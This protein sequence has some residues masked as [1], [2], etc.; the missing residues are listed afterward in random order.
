MAKDIQKISV[1]IKIL[2]Y[3]EQQNKREFYPKTKDI[4]NYLYT[5][6]F[7]I[8]ERSLNRYISSIST[9]FDVAIEKTSHQGGYYINK[10]G[11]IYFDDI[12][13]TLQLVDKA[14]YFKGLLQNSSD[15]LQYFSFYATNFKGFEWI[16]VIVKAIEHKSIIKFKHK[17]FITHEESIREIEPYLLKEYLDR[18]YV[19][20]YDRTV[21]ENRSFGL[22]RISDLEIVN[23]KFKK[24]KSKEIKQQFENTIGLVY[25]EPVIVRLSFNNRLIDYFKAN[26]W[27]KDYKIIEET[28]DELI[29][30]F[31][32]SLNYELEQKILMHNKNVKILEPQLLKD[33]VVALLKESM[34]QYL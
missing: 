25:S 3:I 21:N 7:K 23:K 14:L 31:L 24:V 29:V 15:V 5:I 13:Q 22:D 20:G 12:I 1:Y 4:I 26:P 9:E 28:E 10:E 11:S 2:N 8:S 17:R 34:K 18:W 16:D 32:L 6:D 30:E 33:R 27:H 19:I